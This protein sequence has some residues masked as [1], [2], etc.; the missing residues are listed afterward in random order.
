MQLDFGESSHA[1]LF[2]FCAAPFAAQ[3]FSRMD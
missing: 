2:T 3:R 1:A